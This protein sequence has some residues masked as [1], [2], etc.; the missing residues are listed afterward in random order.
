[1]KSAPGKYVDCESRGRKPE[2]FVNVDWESRGRKPERFVN[3]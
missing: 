1:M 3:H 2:R